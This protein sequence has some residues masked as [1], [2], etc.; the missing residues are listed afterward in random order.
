MGIVL[1]TATSKVYERLEESMT[2]LTDALVEASWRVV[3][4]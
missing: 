4:E 1:Q 3:G 2:D